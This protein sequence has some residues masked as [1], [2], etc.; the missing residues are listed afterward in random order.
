MIVLILAALG[1]FLSSGTEA[2]VSGEIPA[3]VQ[4]PTAA[5][6][7]DSNGYI[8]HRCELAGHRWTC[9]VPDGSRGLVTVI[10]TSQVAY[11]QATSSGSSGMQVA[12]W[13]SAMVILPA[14]V[15]EDDLRNI[16][17]VAKKPDRSI[18]RPR[19]TRF[20]TV[21]Q[22]GV[23]VMKLS[24]TAFWIAGA[25]VDPDAFLAVDGPRIASAWVSIA[26]LA[27]NGSGQPVAVP[28]AAPF[29]LTG[30]VQNARGEDVE[31][32]TVD[33]YV[34]LVSQVSTDP[35][36]TAHGE[37]GKVRGENAN[38]E[39]SL[40]RAMRVAESRSQPGGLFT[41]ERLSEG[42]FLLSVADPRAGRA[43]SIVH[44]VADAVV[45]RLITPPR[46]S[47]RVLRHDLPV[48]GATVRFVPNPDAFRNSLDAEELAAEAET[49]DGEGRF[50]ILLPP[51]L[52]GVVAIAAPD[53][54]AV[55]VHIASPGADGELVLGD[56]PVPDPVQL[57]IRLLDPAPCELS[58]AGPL[59]NLGLSV[60]KGR[61]MSNVYLFELPEPGDWALNASCG[62]H[63]V[64]LQPQIVPVPPAG[65]DPP[66][67]VDVR[68]VR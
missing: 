21:A 14:G 41:F 10:G 11:A 5:E 31:G 32:I 8:A 13:G 48:A 25:H 65:R 23:N 56:I 18:H 67:Q 57:A 6:W 50:S 17:I 45:L 30:R 55:R 36:E 63:S 46:A 44:S 1:A 53:G 7:I 12:Q 66:S 47:G 58:A 68:I 42:P 49:S 40:F 54:T 43:S 59:G 15:V 52:S 9:T 51:L 33:L 38:P 20:Q 22:N 37:A 24:E 39:P 27:N 35:Q 28:A 29:A 64:V 4:A 60:V 16:R 34:P 2:V 19:T 61:A 3:S 26:T 62:G